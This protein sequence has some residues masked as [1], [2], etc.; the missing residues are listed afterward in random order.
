MTID[1]GDTVFH[2][3]SG[4]TWVVAYV[5]GPHLSWCVWPG[6][7]AIVTDCRIVRKALDEER[8]RLLHE[9]AGMGSPSD[10]RQQYAQQVLGF[11]S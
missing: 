9:L 10:H 7:L 11:I 2:I 3:P 8:R 1:T 5:Q 4:E 6:G